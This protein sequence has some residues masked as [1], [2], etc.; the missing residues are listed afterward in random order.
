MAIW[1]NGRHMTRSS[2]KGYGVA[3][4]LD[5]RIKANGDRFNRFLALNKTASTP[6]G[7]GAKTF[8]PPVTAGSMAAQRGV[9]SVSEDAYLLSGGPMEGSASIS[10]TVDGGLSLVVGLSGTAAVVSLSGNGMVLKLTIGLSGEGSWSLTGSP[11]LA[12]I[13]PFEGSGS[14]SMTGTSDLRGLLSME[15]EWT[16][17]TELSPENLARAV[18]DSVLAQYQ[19]DGTAGKALSTASSGGVDLNALAQAVHGY[20]IESGHTFEEVTRVMAAI[21]AGKVSGA[22]TGTE[23]FKG[24]DG[25]TDRVVVTVDES[26]NRTSVV[27]DGA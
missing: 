6:D 4:G 15:G 11:N 22:G 26:G 5:A 27:V 1:P 24:L 10:M 13:V 25:T 19:D 3:P 18:W 12:M 16:P 14:F 21:L 20:V 8:V 17:Y 23:T 7:Y 2:Y 9:A